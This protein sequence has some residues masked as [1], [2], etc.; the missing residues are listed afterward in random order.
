MMKFMLI[1]YATKE[2][3]AGRPPDPRLI[4]AIHKLSDDMTK[5]GVLVGTGGLAPSFTGAQVR[6]SG[7]KV[8]VTDGPFTETKELVG[9]YA[10]VQVNSREE[11]IEMARRFFELHA[12]ILGPAYEGGGEVR[13]LFESPNDYECPATSAAPSRS[14]DG[15]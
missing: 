7:G 10:I 12:Q 13:Q 5:A 8:T 1:A 14:G 3:E 9:G 6:L 11:A 2:S 4:D 15:R